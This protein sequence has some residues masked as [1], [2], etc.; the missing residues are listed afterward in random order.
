MKLKKS[1]Q[2][3]W[4]R[5]G[6]AGAGLIAFFAFGTYM[7]Y[8]AVTPPVTPP[9]YPAIPSS[10]DPRARAAY[11]DFYLRFDAENARQALDYNFFQARTAGG[12][13]VFSLAAAV[14]TITAAFAAV[15]AAQ[16][17]AETAEGMPR[18]YLSTH[19]PRLKISEV[20][21]RGPAKGKSASGNHSEVC[22]RIVNI[23][24]ADATIRALHRVVE[25][26]ATGRLRPLQPEGD[27]S[28][29]G[30]ITLVNGAT[31][32]DSCS[33]GLSAKRL[34]TMR[35]AEVTQHSLPTDDGD[36]PRP[37]LYFRGIIEYSDTAGTIRRMG[38]CRR[39]DYV[40][41]RFII[42]ED[43]DFEYSD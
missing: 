3:F 9:T 21:L 20:Q 18:E 36:M 38:F 33:V 24:E 32:A 16:R 14:A 37:G 5:F 8:H 7:V 31:I 43:P 23:G 27:T 19:R 11:E 15:S 1:D 42:V 26:S 6:T 28:P 34:S 39:Y 17:S 25:L 10:D 12:V 2:N 29:I 22:Y 13:M 40:R 35:G 4:I 30:H 41:E